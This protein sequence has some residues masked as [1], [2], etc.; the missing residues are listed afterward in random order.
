MYITQSQNGTTT[1]RE[2]K[3]LYVMITNHW[4]DFLMENANNKEDTISQ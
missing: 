4:Q 1:F 2:L 3:S